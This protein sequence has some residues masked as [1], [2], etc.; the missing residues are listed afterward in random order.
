[1]EAVIVDCETGET[2]VVPL[3]AEQIAQREADA[4][5]FAEAEAA[6]PPSLEERLAA[7][8]ALLGNG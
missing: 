6:L 1:M 2:E 3:T 7:I 5:A 4:A 8:E